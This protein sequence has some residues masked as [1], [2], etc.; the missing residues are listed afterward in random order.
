MKALLLIP[1]LVG[2]APYV[3]YT[4]LSDPR[5]NGDGYD[6]VC[7]GGKTK[8]NLDMSMAVCKNMRGGEFIRLDVEYVWD[9]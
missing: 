4:H 6:L 7:G 1:F 8:K 5:I 2:C 9:R 3:G